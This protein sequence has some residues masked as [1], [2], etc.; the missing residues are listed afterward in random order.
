MSQTYYKNPKGRMI[1]V[2]VL[3]ASLCMSAYLLPRTIDR[4]NEGGLAGLLPGGAGGVVDPGALLGGASLDGVLRA[5]RESAKGS[6]SGEAVVITPGGV[7]SGAEYERL[8]REAERMAPI[9]VVK[10]VPDASQSVESDAPGTDQASA[11][12]DHEALNRLREL[13][14]EQKQKGEQKG[15]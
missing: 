13:I 15:G 10:G 8:R 12:E 14:E 3:C 6:G 4:L 7:K 5:E 2:T 11:A 1:K 9:R